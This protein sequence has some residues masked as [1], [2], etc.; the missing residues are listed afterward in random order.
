APVRALPAVA[1]GVY[2]YAPDVVLEVVQSGLWVRSPAE[3][4]AGHAVRSSPADPA[5]PAVLYDGT[6]PMAADRMRFIAYELLRGLDPS[7][8]RLSRIMPSSEAARG[9]ADGYPLPVA[10]VTNGGAA[11]T[12]AGPAN[13]RVL[14][15]PPSGREAVPLPPGDAG[16]WADH[17]PAPEPAQAPE[18]GFAVGPG[19]VPPQQPSLA[20]RPGPRDSQP[21]TT[22]PRR[23]APVPDTERSVPRTEVSAPEPAAT[24]GDASTQRSVP[25][26]SAV[27]PVPAAPMAPVSA[28]PVPPVSVPAVPPVSGGP[29]PTGSDGPVP[30]PASPSPAAHAEPA[31]AAPRIRLESSTP[32]PVRPSPQ[33]PTR[34]ADGTRD[35]APADG[36]PLPEPAAAAPP[37]ERP[38]PTGGSAVQVQPRPTAAA[39]VVPPQKGVDRE[40]DWVRRSLGGRYDTA[41]A[42]V[43]RVLS[44]S[45]GLH[46][47]PRSSA[48]DALTDLAAIRLYL[49]GA[50]SAIDAAIRAG[51]AGPH[52]PL[53]RCAASGLRRLP[54]YRGAAMVRATLTAAER[55]WY[56]EGKVVTERSFLAAVSTARRGMPG[57]TDVLVWSLTARRT[58]L[59]APDLPDR[60]LF[61][62]GTRFKVLRV[63]GGDRPVVM[64]RELAASEFD[65]HGRV[66]DGRVP[67][68]EIA[69]TGL[70][71][72]RGF[73]REA[74]NGREGQ[75]G[76]P[77]P[78]EYA[79]ALCAAPGLQIQTGEPGGPRQPAPSPGTVPQ[80]GAKP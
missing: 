36:G 63:E 24:G 14:E 10:A 5:Y 60:V 71:Q 9:P 80:K 39:S 34:A 22:Q 72:V 53:A 21:Q 12:A 38:A 79:G 76:V 40:R 29:A 51:T 58:A 37:P 69:L 62:P 75:A 46:G 77:L 11:L 20:P 19:S 23:E 54:S 26:H 1:P 55:G 67:L 65:E 59:V 4:P 74:E 3:S 30:A 70:E 45:P 48:A 18:S 73:W 43:S 25:P 27:P 7:F 8:G 35:S 33:S 6:N 44:E 49:S 61:A 57:N 78:E 31:P 56:Q 64:L 15:G 47:G 41:A 16:T 68:D 52:V 28:G 17:P 42:F 50:T 66:G 2:Q 13:G 32:E